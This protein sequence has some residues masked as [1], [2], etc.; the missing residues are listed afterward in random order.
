LAKVNRVRDVRT[1]YRVTKREAR[2]GG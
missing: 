1:A 2:A